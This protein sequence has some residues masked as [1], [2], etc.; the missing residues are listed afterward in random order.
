[1][2]S[3]VLKDVSPS[4]SYDTN[5]LSK[6]VHRISE[7]QIYY[8]EAFNVTLHQDSVGERR[9]MFALHVNIYKISNDYS[10]RIKLNIS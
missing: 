4:K 8:G 3:I 2:G 7:H 1:M 5:H 9:C 10:I 6:T